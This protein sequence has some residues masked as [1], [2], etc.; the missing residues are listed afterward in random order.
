V[1]GIEEYQSPCLPRLKDE[2]MLHD[3]GGAEGT[4]EIPYDPSRV[5]DLQT[6]SETQ[7]SARTQVYR[8]LSKHHPHFPVEQSRCRFIRLLTQSRQELLMAALGI[9]LEPLGI[10]WRSPQGLRRNTYSL[11]SGWAFLDGVAQ[12]QPLP[13]SMQSNIRSEGHG[14]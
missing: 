4:L 12:L 9:K 1:I 7:V 13:L 2:G 6:H 10:L 11:H 5:A 14:T 8:L 3:Q